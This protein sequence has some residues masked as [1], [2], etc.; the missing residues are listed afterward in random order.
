MPPLSPSTALALSR[1]AGAPMTSVAGAAHHNSPTA[2]AKATA[3]EFESVFLSAMFNQM[4]EGLKGDGPFGG[5]GDAGVWRSF[6]ADE[7]ARN[8]AKAGGIGIADQVYSTLLKQQ[9]VVR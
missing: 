4:F 2:R 9:E 1:Y 6:L 7:Y 8:F 3:E 5:A